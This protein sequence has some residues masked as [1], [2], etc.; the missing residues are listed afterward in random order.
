MREYDD[1]NIRLYTP[2][3]QR[4]IILLAVIIAVPVVMWTITTMVRTYVAAPKAPTFQRLTDNPASGYAR[5]LPQFRHPRLRQSKPRP[6]HRRVSS[7]MP[8]RRLRRPYAASGYQKARRP[9]PRPSPPRR[10]RRAPDRDGG[11]ATL[12]PK[13]G[14]AGDATAN[15]SCFS[16]AD[17]RACCGAGSP[18][19]VATAERPAGC[20]RQFRQCGPRAGRGR[21]YCLA[22]S[23]HQRAAFRRTAR[24]GG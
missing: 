16:S 17:G 3:L 24:R 1:E 22:K 7:P 20:R 23:R 13:A 4:V 19:R 15:D 9:A 12:D 5:P 14:R 10:L 11:C 21:Q 2:V 6:P 8:E 18:G